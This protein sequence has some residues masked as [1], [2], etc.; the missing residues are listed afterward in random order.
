MAAISSASRSPFCIV[1][2]LAASAASSPAC[3]ALDPAFGTDMAVRWHAAGPSA[4]ADC[5]PMVRL[6]A[7]L[8]TPG[9]PEEVR[10]LTA[11]LRDAN[12]GKFFDA[13]SQDNVCSRIN[14]T[15]RGLDWATVR[16]SL[17]WKEQP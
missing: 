10:L 5:Q 15:L 9:K 3:G 16:R 4:P 7:D 11:W 2:R 14:A 17:G 6:R 8:I 12:C 1:A 13:P